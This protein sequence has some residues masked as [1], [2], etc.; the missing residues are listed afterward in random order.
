M[1]LAEFNNRIASIEAKYSDFFRDKSIHT[2]YIY[3]HEVFDDINVK[4]DG[5]SFPENTNL[6]NDIREEIADAFADTFF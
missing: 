1:S 4:N 3:K 2:Y 6:P 5:I